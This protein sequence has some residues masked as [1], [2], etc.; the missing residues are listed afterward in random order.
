MAAIRCFEEA[1]LSIRRGYDMEKM[2]ETL[3]KMVAHESVDEGMKWRCLLSSCG[4]SSN[5]RNFRLVQGYLKLDLNS[6]VH[7]HNGT[8]LHW[9][10]NTGN[11][12]LINEL[13]Y[14]EKVNVNCQ[15]TE[16]AF[17]DGKFVTQNSYGSSSYAAGVTPLMLAVGHVRMDVVV[18][19]L[20]HPEVDIELKDQEGKTAIF[21]T[22]KRWR[23]HGYETKLKIL[24][25]LVS[26]G[27]DIDARSGKVKSWDYYTSD[28]DEDDVFNHKS[29]EDIFARYN[30]YG[31]TL[32]TEIACEKQPVIHTQIIKFLLKLGCE[33]KIDQR[34]MNSLTERYKGDPTF[35]QQPKSG[36]PSSLLNQSRAVIRKKL[37]EAS[38]GTWHN[39]GVNFSDRVVSL[40]SCGEISEIMGEYIKG[41]TSSDLSFLADL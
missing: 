24:K 15:T 28:D 29:G 16:K 7:G 26:L 12:S 17:P 27:A 33:G 38:K 37:R 11:L 23:R 4:S 40:V 30:I 13:L 9:A 20:K 19:L 35:E 22:L 1:E 36:Q 32:L 10:S 39:Q 25:L 5:L 31:V 34:T 18:T 6:I 3:I 8:L 21:Y 2:R 14:V 41:L